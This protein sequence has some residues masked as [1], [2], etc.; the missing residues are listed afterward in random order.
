MG[1]GDSFAGARYCGYWRF[2][3]ELSEG[4]TD[5]VDL[6]EGGSIYIRCFMAG[7]ANSHIPLVTA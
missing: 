3:S 4:L 1:K 5:F 7:G 6:K 2:R